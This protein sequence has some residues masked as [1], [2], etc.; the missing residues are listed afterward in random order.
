[1]HTNAR[2]VREPS[3]SVAHLRPASSFSGPAKDDD[4]SLTLLPST[5]ILLKGR[6]INFRARIGDDDDDTRDVT[7]RIRDWTSSDPTVATINDDGHLVALRIGRICT[8]SSN[9]RKDS[10]TEEYI[11]DMASVKL[12]PQAKLAHLTS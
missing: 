6:S 7:R 11:F 2:V 8:S 5:T 1:M 10:R 12:H 9:V 4:E 3:R